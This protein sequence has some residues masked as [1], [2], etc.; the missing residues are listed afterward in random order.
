MSLQEMVWFFFSTALVTDIVTGQKPLSETQVA[1][2]RKK[3]QEERT[4]RNAVITL[5]MYVVYVSAI[6]SISYMER[7]QRAFTFK[8]SLDDYMYSSYSKVCSS[9]EEYYMYHF[10]CY[11]GTS[12]LGYTGGD[13]PLQKYNT[14]Q[15]KKS[16]PKPNQMFFHSF[17]EK[18]IPNWNVFKIYMTINRIVLTFNA[19]KD[20]M[21]N[22]ALILFSG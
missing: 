1:A 4:A 8:Q 2:M 22:S 3:R 14:Y 7:D 9:H 21:L 6:Y 16:N 20:M 18:F 13:N 19:S 15:R 10:Y 11:F 5:L 12:L 17:M